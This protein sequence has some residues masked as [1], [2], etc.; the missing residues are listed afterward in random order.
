MVRLRLR[1]R[2]MVRLRVRV[3]GMVMMT[4]GAPL[5][6]P[7]WIP[8]PYLRKC[9]EVGCGG[10]WGEV[11]LGRRLGVRRGV[12]RGRTRCQPA[13]PARVARLWSYRP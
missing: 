9:S 13:T 7:A 11:R 8:T 4:S 12:V 1:L 6:T 2:G 3:R 10:V 5:S